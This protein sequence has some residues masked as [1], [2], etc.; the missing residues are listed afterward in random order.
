MKHV[1]SPNELLR[2]LD[3]FGVND[4]DVVLVG[5]YGS[6][7]SPTFKVISVVSVEDVVTEDD[8]EKVA[9]S[10]MDLDQNDDISHIFSVV[11]QGNELSHFEGKELLETVYAYTDKAVLD[12]T[13]VD[14]EAGEWFSSMCNNGCCGPFDQTSFRVDQEDEDDDEQVASDELLDLIYKQIFG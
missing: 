14:F 6:I 5:L 11:G 4:M 9:A 1:K 7:F 13:V 10:V 8:L 2:L 12:A 3:S